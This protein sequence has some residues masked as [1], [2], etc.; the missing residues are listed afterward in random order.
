MGHRRRFAPRA[1]PCA[2][3]TRCTSSSALHQV[4]RHRNGPPVGLAAFQGR[5]PDLVRLE[6]DVTRAKAKRFG[7]PAPGHRE[8]PGEGLHGGLRMRARHGEEALALWSRQVLATARADELAH[9]RPS[10][11]RPSDPERYIS[12]WE[13]TTAV[14]RPPLLA[15]HTLAVPGRPRPWHVPKRDRMSIREHGRSGASR[16]EWMSRRYHLLPPRGATVG[17]AVVSRGRSSGERTKFT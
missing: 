1:L 17:G 13:L 6:V 16:P 11:N 9:H 4:L 10:P 15:A 8:G 2:R 5:D 14:C 7:G 12:V 3:R